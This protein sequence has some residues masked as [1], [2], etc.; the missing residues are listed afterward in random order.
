[1][2][3]VEFLLVLVLSVANVV[4]FT[5]RIGTLVSGAPDGTRGLLLLGGAGGALVVFGPPALAPLVCRGRVRARLILAA[6][7]LPGTALVFR[8]A[9][10][11]FPVPTAGIPLSSSLAYGVTVSV[12]LVPFALSYLRLI[13]PR[14]LRP[15]AA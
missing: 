12:F 11:A 14:R 8:S 3:R 4:A 6:A 1:M 5:V 13:R 15:A 9:F 2:N 10:G 7:M